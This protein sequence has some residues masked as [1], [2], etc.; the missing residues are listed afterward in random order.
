MLFVLFLSVGNVLYQIQ[1]LSSKVRPLWNS[2]FLNDV[3]FK[4][5]IAELN[6]L[7]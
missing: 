3:A 5:K 1:K 4:K 6:A 2:P 7:A